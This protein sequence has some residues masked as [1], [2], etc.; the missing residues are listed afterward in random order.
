MERLSGTSIENAWLSELTKGT[1]PPD[2]SNVSA[3]RANT[4]KFPDVGTGSPSGASRSSGSALVD[5]TKL[6]P[7]PKPSS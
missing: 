2:H 3:S 5:R 6:A 1:L 7:V 4:E